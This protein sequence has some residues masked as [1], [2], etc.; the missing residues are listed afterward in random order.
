MELNNG[1]VKPTGT[2]VKDYRFKIEITADTKKFL[3]PP[4]DD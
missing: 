3:Y 2:S 1:V 4:E